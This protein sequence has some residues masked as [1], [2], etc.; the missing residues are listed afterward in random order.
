MQKVTEY[1]VQPFRLGKLEIP[2]IWIDGKPYFPTNT[3]CDWLGNDRVPALMPEYIREHRNEI[4]LSNPFGEKK[5]TIVDVYDLIGLTLIISKQCVE[6]AIQFKIE[7]ANFLIKHWE[8]VPDD[9]VENDPDRV[10]DQEGK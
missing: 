1:I 9:Q 2:A 10:D 5:S 6:K 3:I 8:D 4:E 7:L